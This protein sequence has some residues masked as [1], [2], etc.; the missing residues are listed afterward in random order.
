MNKHTAGDESE[1]IARLQQLED[2]PP[3]DMQ[4]SQAGLAR[5]LAEAGNLR[6][7]ASLSPSRRL[8]RWM[9]NLRTKEITLMNRRFASAYMLVVVA[10]IVTA[11]LA[12][13]VATAYA[14]QAAL[15]GSTLYPVKTGL[16][17]TELAL[18]LG[19]ARKARLDLHFAEKR[20]EEMAG[21]IE[22]GRFSDLAP[23]VSAFE[24]H[25][26]TTLESQK[27]IALSDP[28]EAQRLALAVTA[29]LSRYA[30]L[31][32]EYSARV[33]NDAQAPLQQAIEV[34]TQGFQ[35]EL[36]GA[37]RAIGDGIWQIEVLSDGSLVELVVNENT[38]FKP[39]I[40]VDDL[41]KVEA[42]QDADGTLWAV[43]IEPFDDQGDQNQNDN[44]NANTNQNENV[45]TNTNEDDN[46][47]GNI[48]QNQ[49]LNENENAN[50]NENENLNG[51]FNGNTNLNENS[52]ADENANGNSNDNYNRNDNR[53][54]DD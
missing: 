12:S 30:G 35:T 4:A 31:L 47:N 41:V 5:F 27:S 20:L 54:G 18:S 16:E 44:L 28:A 39:G 32:T 14:S 49:N 1:I 6:E 43:E 50:V 9:D 26:Q 34:S 48:N 21:L 15:P 51:N 36:I 8:R 52:S 19:D 24:L 37:V 22:A 2:V 40:A 29:A 46:L 53:S 38:E 17:R 23:V 10:I 33:P 25:I 45:D 11:L 13:T 42:I 3:R 7:T